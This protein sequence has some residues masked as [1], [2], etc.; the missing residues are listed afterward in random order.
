ML[1]IWNDI[2]E[3]YGS[4][5]MKFNWRNYEIKKDKVMIHFTLSLVIC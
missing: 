4:K 2:Y 3:N 5:T 1:K